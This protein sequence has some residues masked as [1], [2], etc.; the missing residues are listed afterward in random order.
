MDMAR[1]KFGS[2]A[3]VKGRGL[4]AKPKPKPDQTR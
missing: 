3:V 2:D 1:Q 4:S